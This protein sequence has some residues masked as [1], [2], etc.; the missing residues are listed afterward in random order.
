M[1]YGFFHHTIGALNIDIKNLNHHQNL[2][3]IYPGKHFQNRDEW[4][5]EWSN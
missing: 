3:D 5:S 2:S 4:S 1:I